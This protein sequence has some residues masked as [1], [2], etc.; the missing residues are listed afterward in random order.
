MFVDLLASPFRKDPLIMGAMMITFIWRHGR[1]GS[2]V[3]AKLAVKDLLS[4]H[5]HPIVTR[6]DFLSSSVN[7][8][9]M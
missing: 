9:R 7:F 3:T 8:E 6:C 4:A 2:G 5:Q 1:A